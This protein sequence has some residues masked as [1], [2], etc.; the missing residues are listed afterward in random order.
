[1]MSFILLTILIAWLSGI[2]ES[3]WSIAVFMD[4]IFPNIYY[5][6]SVTKNCASTSVISHRR[7]TVACFVQIQLPTSSVSVIDWSKNYL[8]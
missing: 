3:D 8:R 1:M 5:G 7:L 2:L 6:N 4:T